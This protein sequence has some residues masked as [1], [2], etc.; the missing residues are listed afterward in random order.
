MR[1]V[2]MR[3]MSDRKSWE[4]CNPRSKSYYRYLRSNG[5]KTNIPIGRKHYLYTALS[6]IFSAEVD[7]NSSDAYERLGHLFQ[8]QKKQSEADAVFDHA[9]EIQRQMV[10]RFPTDAFSHKELGIALQLRGNLDEA[11]LSYRQA[12]ELNPKDSYTYCYLASILDSQNK[13]SEAIAL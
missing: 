13:T 4:G 12:I 11:A 7:P 1:S 10:D 8:Y 3:L 2:A 5:C 6:R 9:I